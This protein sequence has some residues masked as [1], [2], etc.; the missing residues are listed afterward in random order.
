MKIDYLEFVLKEMDT[1]FDA[2]TDPSVKQLMLAATMTR[3]LNC[4]SLL[5]LA[6]THDISQ[7]KIYKSL[8][9]ITPTRWLRRLMKR[10]RQRLVAHLRNWHAG[11]APFKSRHFITLCADDC[12]RTA[13]GCLGEWCGLFYSGAEKGVVNG[14]NI[15]ILCAV[16]GDGLEVIILDVRLV[17]PDPRAGG[18]HSLNH[19][20]WLRRS[21]RQL[22]TFVKI[23]GATLAGCALSA[24]AAYVSPE[25]V[26]LTKELQMHMVSK[27]SA[28][29]KV[30]GDADGSFTGLVPDFAGLAII[31][32]PRISRLLPGDKDVE[33]QRN[34]VYVP[35]LECEVL[36]V[37][38]I[39]ERDFL[40]YFSTN[41]RMKTITLRNILRYR[42]QLERIFWILK[43][44]IG[45]GDIHNHKENRV[46]TRVYLHVIL[47]QAARDAAGA[48]KCSPKDI[49]RDIRKSPDRILHLLG[50]PSTFAEELLVSS[51]PPVPLA[52]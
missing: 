24:D 30:T 22:S 23:Q 49:L 46:E 44:D 36:M 4:D 28:N 17:P 14:L 38:F 43:Q 50:F 27:L 1:M 32:N 3:F 2:I 15:E 26:A 13:R 33:F 29:R 12:T 42:W 11:D 16:I 9:A 6:Q 20:Q 41:L 37:T 8:D 35:S 18:R 34:I 10:G 31:V 52:A 47:A 21:L 7:G 45:I 48:F 51:V 19:N 40:V 39:Y 25:N 5:D